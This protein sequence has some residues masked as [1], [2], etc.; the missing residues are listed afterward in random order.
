MTDGLRR[1]TKL[2]TPVRSIAQGIVAYSD[3]DVAYGHYAR[4]D[5]RD[6]GC[7]AMYR[8]LE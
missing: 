6:L 5:Y 2:R 4:A 1:R 3:F 8:H 7:Y